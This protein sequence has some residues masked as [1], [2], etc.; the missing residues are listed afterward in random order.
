MPK[1]TFDLSQLPDLTGFVVLIT[2]GHSGLGLATTKILA[3]QHAKVYIASRSVP[4]AELAVNEI[5]KEV[6]HAGIAVIEMDLSDLDSVKRGAEEFLRKEDKVHILINNAGIMCPPY[7]T[8]SQG[9]EVQFQTNYLAHHLLTRLLLPALLR[10]SSS[11]PP[12]IPRIINVASDAHS[13]LVSIFS[14]SSPSFPNLGEESTWTRYGTSK[15]CQ[16]LHSK[17]LATHYPNILSLSL[18]PG[19]V[20]TGLSAG[21]R[22]STAWYRFVQPLVELGAPGPEQGCASIVF[23][24]VSDK[25]AM[26]DNGGYFLPVGKKAKASKLGEDPGLAEELWGWSERKLTELGY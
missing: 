26:G 9:I 3:R 14:P 4:K 17:A 22:G 6:S 1:S 24:A 5:N 15:L 10:T 21:P 25:I 2:G 19:T 13:K 12:I 8:T 20:K 18:H 11:S 7:S 16:V 23:C